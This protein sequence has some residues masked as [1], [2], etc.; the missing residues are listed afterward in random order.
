MCSLP[1]LSTT[2]LAKL[3]SERR[4]YFKLLP[5]KLAAVAVP[6]HSISHSPLYLRKLSQTEQTLPSLAEEGPDT[7][8]HMRENAQSDFLQVWLSKEFSK[9]CRC[10]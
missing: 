4:F 1:A 6:V 8:L 9:L 3:W 10:S 5:Q 2:L 7:R